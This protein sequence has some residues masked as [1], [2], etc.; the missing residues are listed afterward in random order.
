[1]KKNRFYLLFIILTISLS[2]LSGCSALGK[3]IGE[4]KIQQGIEEYSKTGVSYKSLDNLISG[5][6]YFPDSP[7]GV[8]NLKKQY[9][10]FSHMKNNIYNSRN[11]SLDNLRKLELYLSITEK[12]TALSTKLPALFS[13]PDNIL[14]ERNKFSD[15]LDTHLSTM[16]VTPVRNENIVFLKSY[17]GFAKFSNSQLLRNKIHELTSA[18]TIRYV[19]SLRFN[20]YLTRYDLPFIFKKVSH[21]NSSSNNRNMDRNYIQFLGNLDSYSLNSLRDVN[22]VQIDISSFSINT[23]E[24]KLLE[25]STATSKF[26]RED[27]T[28][29]IRGTYRLFNSNSHSRNSLNG[30]ELNVFEFKKDFSTEIEKVGNSIR[31]SDEKEVVEEILERFFYEII[32]DEIPSELS[33]YYI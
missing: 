8:E 7:V 5:L 9:S 17:E 23:I 2:L 22:L 15:F 33:R 28:L 32:R 21:E 1:M 27:K 25:K 24:S 10:D 14:E 30:V 12:I 11:Y 4:S 29:T 18:V 20:P 6:D 3:F 19:T 16:R 31:R 13:T 26:F